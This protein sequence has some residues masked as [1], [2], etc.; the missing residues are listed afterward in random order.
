[1]VRVWCERIHHQE[2]RDH[3]T[4]GESKICVPL[5]ITKSSKVMLIN[6]ARGGNDFNSYK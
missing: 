2:H 6:L 1:M 3:S 4:K 5:V